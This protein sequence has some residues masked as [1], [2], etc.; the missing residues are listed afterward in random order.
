MHDGREAKGRVSQ[1]FAGRCWART[2]VRTPRSPRPSDSWE[3][4]PVE[5]E[6]QGGDQEGAP[7]A[8][9]VT[10]PAPMSQGLPIQTGA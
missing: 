6:A 8:A 5:T 4:P 3:P 1:A 7:H 2:L 9:Q 10:V